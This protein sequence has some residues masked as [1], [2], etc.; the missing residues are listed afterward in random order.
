LEP[1]DFAVATAQPEDLK[2][3][4]KARNLEIAK[5]VLDGERGPQRD[6]VIANAAAAIVAAGHAGTFLEAAA[7]AAVS[8]DTGA[9]RD[10]ADALAK[11]TKKRN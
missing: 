8:I 5:A 3:G 10:K 6:I 4:D 11:F 7:I 1:A 2:G 9:A